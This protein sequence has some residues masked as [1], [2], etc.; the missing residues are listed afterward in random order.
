MTLEAIAEVTVTSVERVEAA[1]AWHQQALHRGVS[2]Q[3][4]GDKVIISSHAGAGVY[5]RRYSARSQAKLSQAASK[6]LPS[7][8]TSN[9]WSPGAKSMLRGSIHLACSPICNK[10]C[11]LK[12]SVDVPRS[13]RRS[14]YGTTAEFLRLLRACPRSMICRRSDWSTVAI[15]IPRSRRRSP[16]QGENSVADE[17][18]RKQQ[19]RLPLS[20]REIQEHSTQRVCV[21]LTSGIRLRAWMLRV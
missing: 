8:R 2:L 6:R 3:C 7:S 21:L 1:I 4:H 20:F 17:S 14:E 9:R 12:P 16:A 11:L 13:E 10:S 5:I 18:V 19:T 15:S